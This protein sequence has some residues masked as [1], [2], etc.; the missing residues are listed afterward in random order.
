MKDG[1]FAKA[2]S[3]IIISNQNIM[4]DGAFAKAPSFLIIF[5]NTLYFKGVKWRNYGVKG[6]KVICSRQFQILNKYG[7]I[8]HENRLLA[9]DSHK[10]SYLSSVQN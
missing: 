3:F 2:P 5:S 8:F 1:A 9:D 10:I 6:L 4:K 7:M